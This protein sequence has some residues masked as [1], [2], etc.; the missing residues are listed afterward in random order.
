M[1]LSLMFVH[2]T[3]QL[4]ILQWRLF[5]NWRVRHEKLCLNNIYAVLVFFLREKPERMLSSLS[6]NPT[7]GI[8]TGSSVSGHGPLDSCKSTVHDQRVPG[9]VTGFGGRGWVIRAGSGWG[10]FGEV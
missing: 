2:R 4:R 6:I 8:V 1:I 3:Y 7:E 10:R 9:P 5:H